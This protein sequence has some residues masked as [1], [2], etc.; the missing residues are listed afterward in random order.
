MYM[1][2]VKSPPSLSYSKGMTEKDQ[3]QNE[4]KYYCLKCERE[5]RKTSNIGSWHEPLEVP[6]LTESSGKLR[7][8]PEVEM[9]AAATAYDLER[10]CEESY[11]SYF[12]GVSEENL[13]RRWQEEGFAEQFPDT[14][15][16]EVLR[17][18][19]EEYRTVTFQRSEGKLW[20]AWETT[21]NNH[22]ILKDFTR[23]Y[24]TLGMSYGVRK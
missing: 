4:D 18:F 1:Q 13:R 21:F 7:S 22:I 12:G 20:V 15:P 10:R 5:H 24:E 9:V 11:T 14:D 3:S 6:K 2:K 17:T 8:R 16:L 19:Q 23:E